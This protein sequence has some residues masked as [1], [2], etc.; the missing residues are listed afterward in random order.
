M[1]NKMTFVAINLLFFKGEVVAQIP[2]EVFGG[3]KKATLDVMFFKFI[4]NKQKQN[5][6][7][8][9]FN[10]NRASVDYKITTTTNLP[11][12]GFT[13]AISYNTKNL[14]GFAPVMVAQV[15]NV[16]VYP[17]AGI[18]YAKI[19]KAYTVFTWLVSETLKNPTIDYF[20]LARYSPKISK[21]LHLFTQVELFNGFATTVVKNNSFVQRVRLGL[22][23]NDWQF[24][25]AADF[26]IIGNT[27]YTTAQNIGGFFRYE[28]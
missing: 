16:G 14:K 12:F 19:G 2:V 25:V 18:Q 26:S 27:S 24:G 13:E 7:W 11:Q 23:I 22:K 5:T 6:A 8:L 15:S 3:N 10:R 4:K 21:R 1:K 20:L 17:K 28:F 9:F